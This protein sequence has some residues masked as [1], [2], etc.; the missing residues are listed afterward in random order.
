MVRH[1][2]E[3]QE[4]IFL[5]GAVPENLQHMVTPLMGQ[6]NPNYNEGLN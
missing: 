2:V 5:I 6:E 3:Q 1:T 4:R